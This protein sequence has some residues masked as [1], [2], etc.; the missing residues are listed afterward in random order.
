MF[1]VQFPSDTDAG[2]QSTVPPMRGTQ[3]PIPHPQRI[4]RGSPCELCDPL[5]LA[6]PTRT[7]QAILHARNGLERLTILILAEDICRSPNPVPIPPAF[8]V[9][10]SQCF[11]ASSVRLPYCVYLRIYLALA[12]IM[13]NQASFAHWM[14]SRGQDGHSPFPWD[15]GYHGYPLT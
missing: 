11:F 5:N 10:A 4:G 13:C 9:V 6:M 15:L 2:Q 8:F 14:F 7:H 3:R 1:W 12:H